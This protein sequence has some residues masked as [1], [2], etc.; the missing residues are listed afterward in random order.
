MGKVQS[1]HFP[2]CQR[3]DYGGAVR[4][5]DEQIHLNALK[6]IILCFTR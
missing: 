2:S 4:A 3:I 6:F 1:K 5:G